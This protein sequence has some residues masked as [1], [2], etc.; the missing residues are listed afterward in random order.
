MKTVEYIC[1]WTHFNCYHATNSSVPKIACL[2]IASNK[3]IIYLFIYIGNDFRSRLYE[4]FGQIEREFEILY[5]DNIACKL[6]HGC[7]I[8]FVDKLD[9]Q[10]KCSYSCLQMIIYLP[11]CFSVSTLSLFWQLSYHGLASV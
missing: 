11:D 4:L 2:C 1:F 7:S 5:A 10:I 8:N 3:F 9:V 6:V